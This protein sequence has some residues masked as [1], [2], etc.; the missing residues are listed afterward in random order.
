MASW[1]GCSSLL[2]KASGTFPTPNSD[3][4]DDNAN[5]H[6]KSTDIPKLSLN[7]GVIGVFATT[8]PRTLAILQIVRVVD[9]SGT[10]GP[11]GKMGFALPQVKAQ[12]W[13]MYGFHS[14]G[15]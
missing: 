13:F 8:T 14:R 4:D 6:T 3:N 7:I 2:V 5:H 12:T 1:N 11:R 10:K 9:T 15:P